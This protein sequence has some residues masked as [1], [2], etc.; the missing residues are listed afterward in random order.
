MFEM[1]IKE[2]RQ[3][4]TDGTVIVQGFPI[5]N[6][7]FKNEFFGNRTCPVAQIRLQKE[8]KDHPPMLLVSVDG[9]HY[10]H[11]RIVF[12]QLFSRYLKQKFNTAL[13][14]SVG[15]PGDNQNRSR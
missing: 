13:Q 8:Q 10:L 6:W 2:E 4:K 3:Y 1:R 15:M 5:A 7:E 11:F 12:L 14:R 9:C